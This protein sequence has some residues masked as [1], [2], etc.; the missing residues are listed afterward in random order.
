MLGVTLKFEKLKIPL[1]QQKDYVWYAL[2]LIFL[3]FVLVLA[4]YCI[5]SSSHASIL[6]L[7]TLND[8][9]RD[10]LNAQTLIDLM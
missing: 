7:E 9:M 2:S 1:F 10:I 6:P 5:N 3:L 8:R 4:F